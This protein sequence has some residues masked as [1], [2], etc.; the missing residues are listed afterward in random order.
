MIDNTIGRT[1][2]SQENAAGIDVRYDPVFEALQTEVDKMYSPATIEKVNWQKISELGSDILQ[3]HSK[4]LT[5]AAYL[6]VALV[7]NHGILGFEVGLTILMDMSDVYWNTLFPPLKKKK[8]RLGAIEWWCERGGNA[9]A[10]LPPESVLQSKIKEL[11]GQLETFNNA[12]SSKLSSSIPLYH[13]VESLELLGKEEAEPEKIPVSEKKEMLEPG[14]E[15][16]PSSPPPPIPEKKETPAPKPQEKKTPVAP[17]EQR[18]PP[19]PSPQPSGEIASL[20]DARR[21]FN[22]TMTH[23]KKIAEIFRVNDASDPISYAIVRFDAWVKV[24]ELPSARQGKTQIP[25]PGKQEVAL[26]RKLFESEKW[27]ELI[28]AAEN[29]LGRYIFWMDLN[30][31]TAVALEKMGNSHGDALETVCSTTSVF[32]CR[33][34]GIEAFRFS[35]GMPFASDETLAWMESLGGGGAGSRCVDSVVVL[36]SPPL[37][38]EGAK[39]KDQRIVEKAKVMVDEKNLHAGMAL[40]QSHFSRSVALKDRFFWQIEMAALLLGSKEERTALPVLINIVETIEN[41]RLQEWDPEMSMRG[42]LI[43]WAG[44]RKQKSCKD[45][46][47]KVYALMARI[48]PARVLLLGG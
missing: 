24:N 17:P 32:C 13:I 26:L 7:K 42:L 36:P 20:G 39:D 40:L 43:A 22:Q 34:K 33:L 18:T 44:L 27:T 16:Q 41:F 23:L 25:S 31:Y 12:M 45:L 2:V 3:N 1:P 5:T 9:L 10:L 4:D 46:T 28:N 37:T 8:R 21:G 29:N 38:G 30:R 19:Q 11:M 14:K 6:G 35:D 48:D 47:D 15:A